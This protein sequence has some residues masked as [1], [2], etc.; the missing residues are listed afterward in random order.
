M[1]LKSILVS[2][3]LVAATSTAALARPATFV[4]EADASFTVGEPLVRDHRD[5]GIRVRGESW[6]R[7]HRRPGRWYTPRPEPRPIFLD[8]TK[9]I[10]SNGYVWSEYTGPI[11]AAGYSRGFSALTDAT[12]IGQTKQDFWLKGTQ[13]NQIQLR[14]VAG[15]T[16]V[17]QVAIEFGP[18]SR[19][20]VIQIN[21]D[22][23]DGAI[24]IDLEGHTRSVSRV[25]VYGT[26]GQRSAYQLFAR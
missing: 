22:L 21:R 11:Y 7:D 23:R 17:T 1:N 5:N 12:Q 9:M 8:N 15:S 14:A 3:A 13:A 6:I 16:F 4:V 19:T 25:G 2:F 26:S 10:R 18:G 20:Q 24:T